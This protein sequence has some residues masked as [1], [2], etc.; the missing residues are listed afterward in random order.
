M[1]LTVPIQ[2]R[3]I[4]IQP[5]ALLHQS[6]QNKEKINILAILKHGGPPMELVARKNELMLLHLALEKRESQFI[7]VPVFML[8]QLQSWE[9]N[10]M[11]G[12]TAAQA[13]RAAVAGKNDVIMNQLIF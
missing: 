11:I 1:G 5:P 10:S 8:F 2:R 7:A 4:T 12:R 13:D 3:P 9:H 6:S